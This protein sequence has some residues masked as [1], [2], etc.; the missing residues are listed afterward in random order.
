MTIGITS[1]LAE[2]TL[3]LTGDEISGMMKLVRFVFEN[4]ELFESD[5]VTAAQTL[6]MALVGEGFGYADQSQE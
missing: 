4:E 1:T 2:L 6:E 5:V 3:P